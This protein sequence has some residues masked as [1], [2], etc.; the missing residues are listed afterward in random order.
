MVDE[1]RLVLGTARQFEAPWRNLLAGTA[2]GDRKHRCERSVDEQSGRVLLGEDPAETNPGLRADDFNGNLLRADQALVARE[3]FERL[4]EG[5]RVERGERDDIELM[6]ERAGAEAQPE[7]AGGPGLLGR[8]PEREELASG[9]SRLGRLEARRCDFSMPQQGRDVDS[10]P[11]EPFE[12][13]AGDRNEIGVHVR[14]IAPR[15]RDPLIR[16]RQ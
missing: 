13:Q 11:G 15:Y 12:Q 7:I 14:K 5:C 8:P 2:P 10:E 4:A 3:P 16:S 1:H 6:R 9:Q